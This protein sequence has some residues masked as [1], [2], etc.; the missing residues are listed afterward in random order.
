MIIH[1]SGP[2][3]AGVEESDL[4]NFFRGR[5]VIRSVFIGKGDTDSFYASVF[6]V[7]RRNAVQERPGMLPPLI[8]RRI[9]ASTWPAPHL[10]ATVRPCCPPLHWPVRHS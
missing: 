5:G 2:E 10:R 4:R 8:S 9:P 6:F 1:Q 3:L 7:E